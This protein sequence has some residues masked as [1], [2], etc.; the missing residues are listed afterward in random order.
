M[1]TIQILNMTLQILNMMTQTRIKC[2]KI[3]FYSHLVLS[4]ACNPLLY[5]WFR[6]ISTEIRWTAENW[7][8][9]YTPLQCL[10][11]T[12]PSPAPITPGHTGHIKPVT[13]RWLA[14]VSLHCAFKDMQTR[15]SQIHHFR[16]LSVYGGVLYIPTYTNK[17]LWRC[18]M[19]PGWGQNYLELRTTDINLIRTGNLGLKCSGFKSFLARTFQ[20]KSNKSTQES[21]FISCQH[22]KHPLPTMGN[23][24]KWFQLLRAICLVVLTVV[25]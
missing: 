1:L 7:I 18:Q 14:P 6:L 4:F 22:Y 17:Y 8:I 9:N 16:H 21:I 24:S 10:S 2:K 19:S 23:F 20:W 5:P 15:V 12:Y 25:A 3:S 11:L 13:D